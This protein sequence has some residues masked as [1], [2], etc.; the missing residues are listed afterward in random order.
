MDDSSI[1]LL[2]RLINELERLQPN[3]PRNHISRVIRNWS[4]R[5]SIP[6]VEIERYLVARNLPL[7]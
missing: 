1:L 6:S 5:L 4:Q 2:D 3:P 7:D